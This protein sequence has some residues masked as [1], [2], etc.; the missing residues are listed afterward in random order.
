MKLLCSHR[1]EQEVSQQEYHFLQQQMTYYSSSNQSFKCSPLSHGANIDSIQ[2]PSL[3]RQVVEQYN[4]IAEQARLA[5]FTLSLKTAE[6][7]KTA[8]KNKYDIEEK[9]M[10]TDRRLVS[11]AEKI[12]LAM[13]DLIG[14]RSKKISERIQ[15]LYQYKARSIAARFHS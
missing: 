2:N 11:D 14:Q 6:E 3:R 12:P 13:I 7:E 10:W 8:F 9:K 1:Y 15:C 4:D 5:M